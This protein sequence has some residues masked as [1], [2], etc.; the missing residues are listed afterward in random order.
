MNIR[1]FFRCDSHKKGATRRFVFV[2]YGGQIEDLVIPVNDMAGISED[3]C[4]AEGHRC[5]KDIEATKAVRLHD[6]AG[7]I[8][9]LDVLPDGSAVLSIVQVK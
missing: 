5:L 2:E 1:V 3:I 8:P 4:G 9:D 7:F 6:G